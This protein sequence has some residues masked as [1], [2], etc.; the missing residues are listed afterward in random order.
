M[1]NLTI[2]AVAPPI[3]RWTRQ[4][5]DSLGPAPRRPN[6]FYWSRFKIPRPPWCLVNDPLLLVQKEKRR[7]LTTGHVT[8]ATVL[9]HDSILEV[10][11]PIHGAADVLYPVAPTDDVDPAELAEVAERLTDLRHQRE[12]DASEAQ[13]A[14]FLAATNQRGFGVRSPI[15]SDDGLETA[16]SSLIVYRHFLPGAVLTRRMI[17]LIIAPQHPRVALPIPKSYWPDDMYDWWLAE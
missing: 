16:V 9:R 3:V 6:W 5:A 12:L 17:P 10:R 2:Q 1:V 11:G 14:Q 7:L 15:A 4:I 8:L 13:F